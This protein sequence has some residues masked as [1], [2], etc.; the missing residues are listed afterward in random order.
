MKK[1]LI[2]FAFKFN[3]K[4]EQFRWFCSSRSA[5]ARLLWRFRSAKKWV[6]RLP[7]SVVRASC[8]PRFSLRW[9]ALRSNLSIFIADKKRIKKFKIK[10]G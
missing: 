2:V 4:F 7:R 8:V 10:R 1:I 6:R 5:V 3:G 9:L